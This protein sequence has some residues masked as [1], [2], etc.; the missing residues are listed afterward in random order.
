L[1]NARKVPAVALHEV[2]ELAAI[3][4]PDTVM[5]EEL[6]DDFVRVTVLVVLFPSVTTFALIEA[7]TFVFAAAPVGQKHCP[8]TPLIVAVVAHKVGSSL[9]AAVKFD[10]WTPATVEPLVPVSRRTSL[11]C[12]GVCSN[13]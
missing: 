10:A 3:G 13:L 8:V 2:A 11:A 12:E 7:A 5:A 9:M 1:P 4:V 6:E